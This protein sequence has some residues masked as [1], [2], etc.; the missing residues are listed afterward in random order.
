MLD[1][2]EEE[3]EDEGFVEPLTV[4]QMDFCLLNKSDEESIFWESQPDGSED[5][6]TVGEMV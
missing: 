5:P 3:D 4:A 1:A 6:E 2:G